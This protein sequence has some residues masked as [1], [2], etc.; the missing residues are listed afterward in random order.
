MSFTI[1]GER[2]GERMIEY[3]IDI[4]LDPTFVLKKIDS[5]YFENPSMCR[6]RCHPMALKRWMARLLKT[7]LKL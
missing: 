3:D 4:S 7:F 5:D 1:D 2:R 6:A